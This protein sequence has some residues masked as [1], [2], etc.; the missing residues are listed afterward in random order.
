MHMNMCALLNLGADQTAH[1]YLA[2]LI[3]GSAPGFL[4]AEITLG[5]VQAP[6]AV[7]VSEMMFSRIRDELSSLPIA[8]SQ[9]RT[10]IHL[11]TSSG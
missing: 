3:T 5:A 4:C 2:L 11:L 7:A 6:V 9:T 1:A 8:H 10:H